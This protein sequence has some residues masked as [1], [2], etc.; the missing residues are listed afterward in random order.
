MKCER[1][2]LAELWEEYESEVGG[3]DDELSEELSSG[4][5]RMLETKFC[6]LVIVVF[7]S[8]FNRS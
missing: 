1:D 7:L 6:Q 3:A 2:I 8:F 5:A 4:S